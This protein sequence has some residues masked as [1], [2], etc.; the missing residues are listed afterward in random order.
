MKMEFCP[1]PLYY[2]TKSEQIVSNDTIFNP[3]TN[4]KSKH[5]R[6]SSDGKKI[7]KRYLIKMKRNRS[8]ICM[9]TG[10]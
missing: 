4:K 5:L 6:Y 9:K 8:L 1:K 3:Q 7:G 2:N 10:N